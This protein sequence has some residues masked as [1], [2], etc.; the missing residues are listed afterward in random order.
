MQSHVAIIVEIAVLHTLVG[1]EELLTFS[2]VF[3]DL[4]VDLLHFGTRGLRTRIEGCQDQ[5]HTIRC[6]V[7]IVRQAIEAHEVKIE[8]GAERESLALVIVKRCA[9]IGLTLV[10]VFNEVVGLHYAVVD[11]RPERLVGAARGRV[12]KRIEVV[13]ASTVG[14]DGE[15]ATLG[16]AIEKEIA[17]IIGR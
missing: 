13:V 9:A 3:N 6:L 14:V 11:L 15:V 2:K 17:A 5:G 16:I 8:Q 7:I 10:D 12:V 1:S 4:A